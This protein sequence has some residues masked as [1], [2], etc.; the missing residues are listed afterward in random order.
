M[1]FDGEVGV[2]ECLEF[3]EAV[4]FDLVV[5]A[6]VHLGEAGGDLIVVEAIFTKFPVL[7]DPVGGGFFGAGEVDAEVDPLLPFG[8]FGDF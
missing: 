5:E 6:E 2:R 3:G 4:L 7:F 8:E 1:M